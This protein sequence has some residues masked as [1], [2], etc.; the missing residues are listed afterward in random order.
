MIGTGRSVPLFE[1]IG[2][3]QAD[4]GYWKPSNASVNFYRCIM[5]KNCQGGLASLCQANHQGPLCAICNPGYYGTLRGDCNVCPSKSD[6]WT[7]L[8]LVGSVTLLALWAQFFIVLRAGASK[9]HHVKAQVSDSYSTQYAM[10]IFSR[11]L[12]K[13]TNGFG[14]M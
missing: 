12:L 11:T 1:N 6:S 10:F 14:V 8:L 7:Y 5:Q 13:R 4:P 3:L 9:M 2:T